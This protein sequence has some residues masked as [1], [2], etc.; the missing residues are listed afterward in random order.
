MANFKTNQ[1]NMKASM[2]NLENQIWQLTN[3]M[4]ESLSRPF[5]SDMEN[6]P[7]ECMASTLRSGKELGDSKEVENEKL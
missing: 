6:N 3:S 5:P 2:I 4:K 7:K 1:A